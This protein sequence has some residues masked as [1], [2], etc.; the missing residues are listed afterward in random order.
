MG[1]DHS[2]LARRHFDV[3][4]PLVTK[5]EKSGYARGETTWHCFAAP[6][7]PDY[8]NDNLGPGNIKGLWPKIVVLQNP[9]RYQCKR[10]FPRHPR[11]GGR[12]FRGVT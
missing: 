11:F 6:I 1:S 7:K 4:I 5:A 12:S 10:S 8:L 3:T 2:R 9:S